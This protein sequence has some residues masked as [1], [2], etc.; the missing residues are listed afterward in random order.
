MTNGAT[1]A[2]SLPYVWARAAL[3]MGGSLRTM[4]EESGSADTPG[5]QDALAADHCLSTAE[6]A[7]S[8]CQVALT[9]F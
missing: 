7:S 6:A 3:R 5:R 1:T 8:P 9:G 2:R 4:F